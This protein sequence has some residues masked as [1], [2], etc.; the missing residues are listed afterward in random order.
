MRAN[1]SVKWA[2][3]LPARELCRRGYAILARRHRTRYGEIDIIAREGET[4]VFVEVKARRDVAFGGAGAAVTIVEAAADCADGERLSGATWPA[5]GT[6]PVRRR[7]HRLRRGPP[8]HRGLHARVH[9][10]EARLARVH[11]FTSARVLRFRFSGH[12]ATD[13][14]V[15]WLGLTGVNRAWGPVSAA[16]CEH[17]DRCNRYASTCDL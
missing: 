6:V 1:L 2:K 16:P 9:W 7:R 8:A 13:S 10:R 4:I 5:G 11:R 3:H 17:L 15:A 14:A 12:D